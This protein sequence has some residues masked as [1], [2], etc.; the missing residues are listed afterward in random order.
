MRLRAFRPELRVGAERLLGV[1][2]ALPGLGDDRP[3]GGLPFEDICDPW[4]SLPG[5]GSTRE[6]PGSSPFVRESEDM[7]A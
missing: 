7:P 4:G 3:I 5:S 6:A 2:L 1:V